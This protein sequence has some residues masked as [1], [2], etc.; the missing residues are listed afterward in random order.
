VYANTPEIERNLDATRRGVAIVVDLDR[1]EGMGP[2]G[3]I[4]MVAAA[5]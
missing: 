5:R 4:R 3:R 1:V 2:G